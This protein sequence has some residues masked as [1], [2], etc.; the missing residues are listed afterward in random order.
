MFNITKNSENGK[1]YMH[2]I[3]EL[4][5]KTAD[6]LRK[7]SNGFLDN[8]TDFTLDMEGLTY[9]TSAGLRIILTMAKTMEVQGEMH[10]INVSK[11][12]KDILDVTGF[13]E[14][15]SIE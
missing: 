11:S 2:L 10:V 9:I 6:D 1:A 5:T 14:V 3:G 4:D 15:L 8:I 12:V 13:T 7:E